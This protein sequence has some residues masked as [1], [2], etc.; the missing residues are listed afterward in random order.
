M[1][2]EK[3]K[4]K[5]SKILLYIEVFILLCMFISYSISLDGK[6][7]LCYLENKWFDHLMV[8]NVAKKAPN[9]RIFIAAIDEKTTKAL[10]YPLR[11]KYYGDL[12]NKLA[13]M[14]TRVITMDVMFLEPSK[15]DPTSDRMFVRAVKK[16]KNV[17]NLAALTD[18]SQGAKELKLPF[19]KDLMKYSKYISLPNVGDYIDADGHIRKI[20]L[21][22]TGEEQVVYSPVL[23]G[24]YGCR[25]TSGTC[26]GLPVASLAAATYAAYKNISLKKVFFNQTYDPTEELLY[27]NFRKPEGYGVLEELPGNIYK[28]ISIV[29]ILRGN[30]NEDEK[31]AIKGGIAFVGSTSLGTFDHYPS[32]FARHFPGVEIHATALDNLI[33]GDFLTV[34]SPFLE[35]LLLVFFILLPYFMRKQTIARILILAAVLTLIYRY[36]DGVAFEHCKKLVFMGPILGLWFSTFSVVSNKAFLEGKEKKWIKNTFGQY[37][38][39]KVVDIVVKDPSKLELGGEKRDMSVFFLDIA[40]FTSISEKLEPDQLTLLLNRYLSG[41][42]DVILRYDG[43]VDKYI[44]D[45]IMAFW[46]APLD[47]KEHRKLA[48]CAAIDCLE[49]LRRLNET[50]ETEEKPAIRIGVNSGDMVVGNMGSRTRFSYTVLGDAVNLASRLEG[51]NK[52]FSSKI[53]ASEFTYDEAKRYIDARY[54]GKIKV[55]GKLIPVKVYEPLA[56]KGRLSDKMATLL[57]KYNSGIDSFYK[58][59]YSRS[60]K[61]FQEALSI[62]PEDGPSGF[63]L[64]KSEEYAGSEPKDWN[65]VF[66]LTSK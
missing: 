64:K 28:R 45:C 17:I 12:I 16:N 62:V 14:G 36:V 20:T 38:S 34:S 56:H 50:A 57:E 55:V 51:A 11:R 13:K 29:D 15:I 1:N 25:K 49:E 4:S 41:L 61:H 27:L 22:K 8:L 21:F 30:L 52:F 3:R 44:G 42:T 39:P 63:Y 10:G 46:N 19:S 37:L 66:N 60:A 43:V 24:G 7:W 53:M 40:H 47:Q 31:K 32:F 23:P 5:E 48:C 59:E 18:T 9:P 6:G 58:G 35:T 26:E 65:G 54:L 2:M 33:D